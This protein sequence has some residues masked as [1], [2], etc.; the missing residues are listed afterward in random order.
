MFTAKNMSPRKLSALTSAALSIPIA[1]GIYLIIRNGTIA[2]IS[3]AAIWLGSYWL[4]LFTLERFIYRKIKLIYKLIYQ[5]KATKKEEV[6]FKYVLPDKSIDQVRE[7]V[8]AWGAKRNEEIAM[9]QKNEAYRKEFLQNLSHEFKT[10]IFAIQGYVDALLNGALEE[11]DIGEKFLRNTSKNVERL[12]NLINDLDEITR[13]ESGEQL[14]YKQNFIIQDLIRE[15]YDSLDIK[16][17]E[18]NIRAAIKKGCEAPVTVFADKE[19]IRQ[20]LTNLVENA[21]KYGKQG[22]QIIASIYTTDDKHALI[23]IGDDGIG[24]EEEHLPRIFE[25]FYR[26][27]AA[28]SRDKGGTGLGLAICKHII[29]AHGQ[30]IH[31]RSTPEVGST[32]GFS[33]ELK[34]ES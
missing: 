24:I 26:T 3:L 12:V 27:D 7:D 6:Y 30:N 10:P 31:A 1:L 33:L 34:R 17:K 25:R 21:C 18:K 11:Q 13:L 15:V 4:I 20:T 32:I 19:K 28:R 9:L 29:E 5:T 8:E 22:G 16:L 14:L 23:E 2:L